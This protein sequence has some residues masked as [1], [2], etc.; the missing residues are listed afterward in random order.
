VNPWTRL[1]LAPT[2]DARAIKRAYARLLKATRPEDDPAGFQ[3]LRE[4]YEWALQAARHLAEDEDEA[5]ADGN[6]AVVVREPQQAAETPVVIEAAPAPAAIPAPAVA[7]APAPASAPV[8]PQ[9]AALQP[10]DEA[11]RIW[12]EY[13]AGARVQPRQRLQKFMARDD[14]LD[15]RVRECFELCAVEVCADA[16]CPD[17]V[18]AAVVGWYGWERDS[19]FVARHRPQQAYE[20]LARWRADRSYEHLLPMGGDK[21]MQ[22]LLAID[23]GR[24]PGWRLDGRFALRMQQLVREIPERH[25]E[26]LHYRLH[27]HVFDT[28]AQRVHGRRYFLS[29]ALG[30]AII[31][32]V[33]WG[34]AAGFLIDALPWMSGWTSFLLVE[35]LTIAV[36]W[37][38]LRAQAAFVRGARSS[39][40]MHHLLHEVRLRPVWQFGWIPLYALAS[41]A[42]YVPRPPSWFVLADG[43]LLAVSLALNVFAVSASLIENPAGFLVVA[44]AAMAMGAPLG[45]DYMLQYNPVVTGLAA[46]SAVLLF[47]R[48]GHDLFTW[49]Q[50]P[51]GRFL[52]LRAAWLAGA[53]LLVLG[54]GLLAP[55]MHPYA[56]VLWLWLLAGVLL[57]RPSIKILYGLL[58]AFAAQIVIQGALRSPTLQILPVGLL[59]YSLSAVAIFMSVNIARTKKHQYPFA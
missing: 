28:W 34:C 50:V 12:A 44:V 46:I 5:E 56:A 23:A 2:G 37:F 21:A 11:R 31:G 51:V 53:A 22:A 59:T 14:M 41:A 42:L 9:P 54:G 40:V 29:T 1:G 3:A 27:P 36:V 15:M 18:R 38:H 49:L 48:G 7:A 17:T 8:A 24:D 57:S 33:L 16:A 52:P 19:A 4:A 55:P 39:R 6:G 10:M 13:I 26:L 30:S 45:K 47:F 35:A 20:A 25:P 32:L 43:A 58:G